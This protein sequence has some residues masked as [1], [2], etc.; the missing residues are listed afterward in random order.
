MKVLVANLGS[1]SFKF[2]L[3]DLDGEHQ[4]ARGAIDRIG[5]DG[6]VVSIEIGEQVVESTASIPDHAVAVGICLDSLTH[7]DTGCLGSVEEVSAIGFKAVFAAELS[8]VRFVDDVLLERME[9]LADV[10]PAHNPPYV[11]A[12]RQLTT[13]FPGIP[14]VAALETGFH[15]TISDAQRA[16]AVP[17]EWQEL[18]VRRWGYHGASHR[19]I[20]TRMAELTGRDDLKVVSCHL[21]GSSSLAAIDGGVSRAASMGMSPQSGLPHNNRVGDFEP[22]ALP[23]LMRATGKGLEELLDDLASRSGLL[24]LSGL[25]GDLRDLEQAADDGHAGAALALEH[26]VLAIR[27]YLA[28]QMAVLGGAD[29]VVFT[30]G[31]GENSVRIRAEVCRGMDWCGLAID[32]EANAGAVGEAEIT[33]AASH[34]ATWVVPTNEELIV[35]RQ[36]AEL[37]SGEA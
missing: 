9:S 25:S 16:Y 33:G 32:E 4:L 31:I 37:V 13:A 11:E 19:Y 1:T 21:G 18:G 14:L 12:M 34:T 30:G 24:G 29:A 20:A 36:A 27:G 8:G 6:S 23:V 7:P 22:F 10:A 35:A 17:A 28:S 3:Y 5:G 26:F 2:R 15:E